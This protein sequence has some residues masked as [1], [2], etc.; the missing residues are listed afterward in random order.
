MLMPFHRGGIGTM[1]GPIELL[2]HQASIPIE[3]GVRLGNARDILQGFASNS[4]RDL[5][6]GGPLPIRQS[7]P[8]R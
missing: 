5:G 3:N 1:P 8:A 7:E 6:Q 2:G 4:F